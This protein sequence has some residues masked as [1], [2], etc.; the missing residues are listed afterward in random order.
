M[1]TGALI[2]WDMDRL[3]SIQRWYCAICHGFRRPVRHNSP[4]P[5]SMDPSIRINAYQL[6]WTQNEFFPQRC[7][8]NFDVRAEAEQQT[9]SDLSDVDI[10]LRLSHLHESLQPGDDADDVPI[11][12]PLQAIVHI[13]EDAYAWQ[14]VFDT[15]G[16]ASGPRTRPPCARFLTGKRART[17]TPPD[18]DDDEASLLRDAN[19]AYTDPSSRS[20]AKRRKT[21]A[22]S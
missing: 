1:S 3:H 4:D 22:G 16:N 2:Y 14:G 21:K 17:S 13:A 7:L 10:G 20:F 19:A 12:L 9:R 11:R 5:P 15:Y 6:A 18:G 8:T